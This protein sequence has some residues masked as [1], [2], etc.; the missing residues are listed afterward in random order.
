MGI[1]RYGEGG[2]AEPRDA[3]AALGTR[4]A[5]PDVRIGPGRPITP[6]G[7]LA[8]FEQRKTRPSASTSC[9]SL[10]GSGPLCEVAPRCVPKARNGH[11]SSATP[12][13]FATGDGEV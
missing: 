2:I 7:P 9:A 5:T 12:P 4:L 1:H 3:A 13:T 8:Q 10:P 6:A 11:A